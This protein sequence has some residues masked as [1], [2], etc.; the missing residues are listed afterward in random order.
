MEVPGGD[1]GD[2]FCL[3]KRPG[4]DWLQYC[5]SV[6]ACSSAAAANYP[7]GEV[8]SKSQLLI[9]IVLGHIYERLSA[10]PRMP[11]GFK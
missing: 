5:N 8:C 10:W 11:C 3:F 6:G 2:Q 1:G 4:L 9:S 7:H